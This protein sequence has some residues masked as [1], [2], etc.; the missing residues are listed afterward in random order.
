M[1]ASAT[2]APKIPTWRDV[3][4]LLETSVRSDDLGSS[5]LVSESSICSLR[6]WKKKTI[7]WGL[8]RDSTKISCPSEGNHTAKSHTTCVQKQKCT[9]W[10]NLKSFT[11]FGRDKMM[12]ISCLYLN[13]LLHNF[14]VSWPHV[15]RVIRPYY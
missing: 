10:T 6:T 7:S 5:F 14:M 15:Q 8:T 2:V 1:P 9:I 11:P 3:T 13:N 12:N 4:L